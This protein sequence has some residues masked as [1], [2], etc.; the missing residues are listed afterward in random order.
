MMLSYTYTATP[1]SLDIRKE[2]K[3][4]SVKHLPLEGKA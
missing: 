3:R 1:P 4:L 2:G